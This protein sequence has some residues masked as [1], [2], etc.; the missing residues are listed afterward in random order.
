MS[1]SDFFN[2]VKTVQKVSGKIS[3]YLAPTVYTQSNS[4]VPVKPVTPINPE[5]EIYV[6][7]SQVAKQKYGKNIPPYFLK[8][9]RQQESSGIVDP[10]DYGRSFGLVN[11]NGKVGAKMEL[12]KEYLPDDSLQNSAINSANYLAKRSNLVREDGSV[13]DLSTPENLSKLYVQRYVGLLPG[14]SRMMPD[15][16]KVTYEKVKQLFEEKLKAN[17]K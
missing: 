1:I 6:K 10:N 16:T 11:A 13:L 12:G 15:G 8:A 14:Q 2:P 3:D 4:V 17:Q 5:D 7:A 9:V